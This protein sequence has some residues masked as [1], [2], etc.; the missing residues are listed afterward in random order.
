MLLIT[1]EEGAVGLAGIM[2]GLR[3]AVSA[4]TRDVFLESAFFAPE[5]ILGRARASGS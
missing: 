5:A 2:G 3:T 1:D 4:D